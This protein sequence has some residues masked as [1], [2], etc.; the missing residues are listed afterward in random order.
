MSGPSRRNELGMTLMEAIIAIVI[1]ASVVVALEQGIATAWRGL[2]AGETARAAVAIARNRLAQAA[3]PPIA[4]GETEGSEGRFAWHVAVTAQPTE[5]KSPPVV[6]A[7]WV[8]AVVSWR[9]R[10]FG[11]PKSLALRTL[12]LQRGQR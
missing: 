4:V 3:A 8:E 1:L 12:A 6:E 2:G 7:F 11:P 10:P 9:D 5:I